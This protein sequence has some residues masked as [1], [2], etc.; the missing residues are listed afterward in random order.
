MSIEET[1]EQLAIPEATVKTRLHRARALLRRGLDEELNSSLTGVFPFGG[2][3]CARIT[4]VVLERLGLIETLPP[5]P[6]GS[7]NTEDGL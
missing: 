3:R 5:G 1:A 2:A 4:E 6:R 7:G